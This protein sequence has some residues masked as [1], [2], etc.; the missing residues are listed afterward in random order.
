MKMLINRRGFTMLEV[1]VSIAVIGILTA[2]LMSSFVMA[3]KINRD[4]SREFKSFLEAQKYMEEIK[5]LKSIDASKYTYDVGTGAYEYTVL[6]SGENYGAII[7]ITPE[8]S[9]LYNIEINII[10]E[11]KV[12]N[13]LFGSR[14]LFSNAAK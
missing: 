8:N 3:A 2:P 13:S 12:V 10:D 6:Q 5:A 4:S 14:I 11:G 7:T 1:I 9:I